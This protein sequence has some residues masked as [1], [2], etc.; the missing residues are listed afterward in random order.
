MMFA[1]FML[2]SCTNDDDDDD[3]KT[4][5][6]VDD[7]NF[8]IMLGEADNLGLGG[9]SGVS[10]SMQPASI[11]SDSDLFTVDASGDIIFISVK[12]KKNKRIYKI[13]KIWK[14]G[15]RSKS[16]VKAAFQ[17]WDTQTAEMAWWLVD[18]DDTAHKMK[19]K[20][21]RS[22][23]WRNAPF[24][25]E[26]NPIFYLSEDD[27][28]VKIDLS[29]D[30]SQDV[31]TVVRSGV[32]QA[33]MGSKG[34]WMLEKADGRVLHWE[35]S[36][37]VDTRMDDNLPG[38]S[39]NAELKKFFMP[40]Q[41]GFI[42]ESDAPG[43]FYR[44]VWRDSTLD[45]IPAFQIDD[46]KIVMY[47]DGMFCEYYPVGNQE[48]MLCGGSL[49]HESRWIYRLGDES[50]D[51]EEINFIWAG[52]TGGLSYDSE[53]VQT[54]VSEKYVY[55]WTK[56]SES[57]VQFTRIDLDN[58]TCAHIFYEGSAGGSCTDAFMTQLY[59]ITKLSVSADDTVRFCGYR[60]GE[61]QLKLVEIQDVT[62]DTPSVNEQDIAQC[63]QLEAL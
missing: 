55:R 35:S 29:T 43:Y 47:A 37:D 23:K 56:E 3:N 14:K 33:V 58:D 42:F 61:T 44:A 12:D 7:G 50:N 53:H 13:E 22:A 17:T 10:A 21:K 46:Q 26:I 30:A 28:L 4:N 59:T 32:K 63:D 54:A 60:L 62:R 52:H 40:N 45:V 19:Y 34:D 31:H 8:Q 9:A 5:P 38:W 1:L 25:Q 51:I 2:I 27:N 11:V 48:L 6:S 16:K 49:G 36:S 18:N 24:F 41:D 20:P 39:D 57:I 15:D